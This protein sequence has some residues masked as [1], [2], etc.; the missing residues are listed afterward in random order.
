MPGQ[1]AYD[2]SSPSSPRAVSTYASAMEGGL[3][4]SPSTQPRSPEPLPSKGGDSRDKIILELSKTTADSV[5]AIPENKR[6][7]PLCLNEFE[8]DQFIS[9]T[10]CCDMFLHVA[11]FSAYVNNPDAKQRCLKCRRQIDAAKRLNRYVEPIKGVT[12]WDQNEDFGVP[13]ALS[14]HASTKLPLSI[15]VTP[16]PVRIRGFSILDPIR[17]TDV[18]P[19]MWTEFQTMRD[20]LERQSQRTF[21]VLS[22]MTTRRQLA[23]AHYQ[24]VHD[25]YA[26]ARDHNTN[27]GDTPHEEVAELRRQRRAVAE[28]LKAEIARH[29]GAKTIYERQQEAHK[30]RRLEFLGRMRALSSGLPQVASALADAHGYS[31]VPNSSPDPRSPRRPLSGSGAPRSRR[32]AAHTDAPDQSDPN[33]PTRRSTMRRG[34]SNSRYSVTESSERS[35]L[36]SMTFNGSNPVRHPPGLHD[37]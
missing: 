33:E 37:A 8:P 5:R 31:D 29:Y 35:T 18:P 19:S 9:N 27:G 32:S 30:R 23:E 21:T 28:E 6:D 10:S 34:G 7:C 26:R 24:A 20:D 12:E 13:V 1:S 16:G 22:N 2:P 17:E 3:P 36:P 15:D 4:T 25:S 11:C 14:D